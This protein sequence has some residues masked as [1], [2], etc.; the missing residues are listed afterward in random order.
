MDCRS[1]ASLLLTSVSCTAAEGVACQAASA[2]WVQACSKHKRLV[3][4]PA[5][6]APLLLLS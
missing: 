6:H 3:K 4:P 2:G 5:Q 1:A